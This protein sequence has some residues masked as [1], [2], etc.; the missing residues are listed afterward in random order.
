MKKSIFFILFLTT[1]LSFA[2]DNFL[3]DFNEQRLKTDKTLMITLGSWSLANAAVSAYGWATTENEAKYFHQMNVM[4]SGVNLALAIPGYFKARKSD[5]STFSF[6]KT[7]DDQ[8]RTEK[9]F[10][11]NT[12]LDVAYIT[13][14]FYLRSRA[15]SD[16]ENYH[17]FR[18]FGNGIILQGSFLFLFDM[19]AVIIHSRHKKRKLSPF[20]EQIS[21]SSNGIGIQINL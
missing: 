5:P 2:Q 4:W 18:G 9:V 14:G 17:R 21:P 3:V 16:P 6:A 11:F 8:E 19:T 10:M 12:A 1:Y 13:S 20:L 7:W 15:Q